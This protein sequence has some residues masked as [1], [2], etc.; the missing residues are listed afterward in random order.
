[1]TVSH[2][3]N[4]EKLFWSVIEV[5]SCRAEEGSY[6]PGEFAESQVNF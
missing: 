4:R 2:K 1:M 5:T 3:K 6:S